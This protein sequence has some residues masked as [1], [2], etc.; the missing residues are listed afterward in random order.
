MWVML[1]LGGWDGEWDERVDGAAWRHAR[2]QLSESVSCSVSEPFWAIRFLMILA[3][4]SSLLCSFCSFC[5]L[6]VVLVVLVVAVVVAILLAMVVFH[7]LG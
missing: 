5:S 2:N 4:Y 1:G 7:D 6:V 3:A